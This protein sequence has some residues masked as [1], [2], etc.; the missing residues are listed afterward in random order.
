MARVELRGVSKAFD[1]V[2]VIP[3]LDLE[4]ADTEFVV[5]VGP[6]GCGKTT[7]LRMIAGL[8]GASGGIITIGGR[9][10]TDLRPGLRNCAMV[11][12]NYALYPHMTVA[13]NIGYGMKVRGMSKPEIAT[14]IG[15]AAR[16][17]GLEPYLDRRPKQLSGG[18]RQR[19]AIGRA[20]VRQ[21]DVF[22]FDEPLSNLDAKLRIE[23]RTEIKNLHRRRNSTMV[24]V[25]HDQVEAMTM[26]DRVVVMNE[27]RIEQAADPI[28][29]YENPANTFVAAFIGAPS[30]NFVPATVVGSDA[31]L[32]LRLNDGSE[33]AIPRDRWERYGAAKDRPVTFGLRPEHNSGGGA[34]EAVITL[35]TRA[36]EPLGPHTLII[37]EAAGHGYTAQ[38][39]SHFPAAPDA[40]VSISLDMTNMHLFDPDSGRAL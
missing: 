1:E 4:I 26:A 20:I 16:I 21:P 5:L 38:V 18:Q 32:A 11:F 8:E 28:T 36:I 15:E 14:R 10:V 31:G 34:G 23:M 35:T 2:T 24:Y 37:G 19:V 30:M 6:S 12:Q 33:L 3:A 25:P 40:Q 22:L 7:T 9:E 27:G 17:L 39:D 13:D 29:L